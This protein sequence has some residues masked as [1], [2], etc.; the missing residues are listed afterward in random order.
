MSS[1]WD[2]SF[3]HTFLPHLI[4]WKVVSF[5]LSF[6]QS[7]FLTLSMSLSSF[8]ILPPLRK[9][10]SKA[11][12]QQQTIL[13]IPTP[14]YAFPEFI[15]YLLLPHSPP[16]VKLHPIQLYPHPLQIL[17]QLRVSGLLLPIGLLIP[18][19]LLPFIWYLCPVNY[20]P[21]RFTPNLTCCLSHHHTLPSSRKLS[22][23]PSW[24]DT[25]S[26]GSR[27]SWLQDSPLEIICCWNWSAI[28]E[29]STY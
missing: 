19:T 2:C 8:S 28:L 10:T 24:Q 26:K 5:Y 11:T 18:L 23:C 27:I 17:C 22:V 29:S 15:L 9:Q 21:A 20:L 16:L 7:S 14:A 12:S 4:I 6:L 25:E 1:V 13:K 3:F